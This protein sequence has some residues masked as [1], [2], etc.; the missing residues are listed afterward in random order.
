MF[1]ACYKGLFAIVLLLP[2]L[3]VA[4]EV[5]TMSD[6]WVRATPPNSRTSAAYFTL[7]NR[8][9]TPLVVTNA[10]ASIA[11]AAE[12][13][14]WREEGGMKRM[15]RM[16]EVPLSPGEELHFAPG[17]KH[18]MMFRL[19]PVPAIGDVVTLCVDTASGD[20]ACVDAPVKMP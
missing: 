19:D 4:Q 16:H 1:A 18:M 11:G 14:N 6:A 13:H 20:E 7:H 17:G 15:Y 2:A 9:D 5:L 3:G 10:R 12:L 8:G